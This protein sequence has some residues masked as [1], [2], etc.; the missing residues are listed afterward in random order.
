MLDLEGARVAVSDINFDGARAVADEIG[1]GA[2]ATRHDVT[3]EESWCAALDRTLAAFGGLHVPVT[4]AG[5]AIA[6]TVEETSPEQWRSE[7]RRV[8]KDCVN[9]CRYRGSR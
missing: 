5:G 9:S 1:D 3:A 7:E 4:C 2:I 8:G 6:G